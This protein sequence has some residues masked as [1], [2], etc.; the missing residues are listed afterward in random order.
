MPVATVLAPR[1]R[2]F[3]AFSSGQGISAVGN[4]AQK[5]AVG[6]L[7]WQLTESAAWVGAIAMSDLIAAIW[8]APLAG[9]VTDRSNPY[10]LLWI[11]QVLMIVL[12][13][14][15]WAVMSA[16]YLTIW[17]LL[18][19]AILDATVSGFNQPVRMLAI[20][21]LATPERMSQAIATNSIA[22]NLA[23]SIGPAISALVMIHAGVQY[24]FLLNALSFSAI[25]GAMIYVR[26]WIDHSGLGSTSGS[27]LSDVMSGFSYVS[28]TPSI[29]VLLLFTTSFALL[30][31]P[32]TELY[33][34]LAGE[35]FKGGPQTLAM[36]MS[37]QGVGALVGA[38]WMLR[39]RN[40]PALLATSFLSA[41]GISMALVGFALTS[42]IFWGVVAMAFAGLFHVVCNIGM[43]SIV[44]TLS[45]RQMRGRVLAIYGLI[46]RSG[47]A[48][49]AFVIGLSASRYGLQWLVGAASA[50]FGILVLSS[51][52]F[53]R[54]VY[55]DAEQGR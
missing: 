52:P 34:A 12:T 31:R 32:F 24:V 6:W 26:R 49:G 46:F 1:I 21:T 8:V 17:F 7:V 29:A 18:F 44:Q 35:I 3:V 36:L 54:K 10:R 14:G 51:L 16:G 9:A 47:P 11:T 28:R 41:I 15:L 22:A 4:W 23:R 39:R 38:G 2:N 25:L 55:A 43:Q 45:A 30:A 27:M 20:G 37:A 33:P 53:A 19:W 50:T 13:L 48:I 40:L 5:A 42:Q